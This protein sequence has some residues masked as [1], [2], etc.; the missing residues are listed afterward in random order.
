MSTRFRKVLHVDA[1]AD[2]TPID[3]ST[4]IEKS[5]LLDAIADDDDIESTPVDERGMGASVKQSCGRV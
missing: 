4:L 3:E 2:L 1:F 5:Q